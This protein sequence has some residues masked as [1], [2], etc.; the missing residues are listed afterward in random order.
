MTWPNTNKKYHIWI[1][2]LKWF[3][4]NNIFVLVVNDALHCSEIINLSI[5]LLFTYIY[6]TDPLFYLNPYQSEKVCNQSQW[7]LN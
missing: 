3:F 2:I 4:Q 7:F 6:L 1:T 5:E